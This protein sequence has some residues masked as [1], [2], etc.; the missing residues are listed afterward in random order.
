MAIMTSAI[1]KAVSQLC[2]LATVLKGSP[3]IK[4]PTV[5]NTT[6]WKG[7]HWN[8]AVVAP[9]VFTGHVNLLTIRHQCHNSVRGST[10]IWRCAFT[11]YHP[12]QG[13]WSIRRKPKHCTKEEDP[14]LC[15][16]RWKCGTAFLKAF[17]E[18]STLNFYSPKCLSVPLFL[19]HRWGLRQDEWAGPKEEPPEHMK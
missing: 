9:H 6:T 8:T 5:T 14:D 7:Q 3:A 2:C 18:F 16:T 17:L 19:T 10:E 1:Q 4:A 15:R 12:K 13:N 11:G